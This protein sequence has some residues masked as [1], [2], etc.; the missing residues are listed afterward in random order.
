MSIIPPDHPL[1]WAAQRLNRSDHQ[2]LQHGNKEGRR[3]KDHRGRS[4]L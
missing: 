1:L 2:R 4:E 3:E